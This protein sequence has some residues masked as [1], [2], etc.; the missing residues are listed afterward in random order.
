MIVEKANGL[1]DRDVPG[2]RK[3]RTLFDLIMEIGEELAGNVITHNSLANPL[4]VVVQC[5]A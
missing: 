3:I 5:L 1:F 4:R 2:N